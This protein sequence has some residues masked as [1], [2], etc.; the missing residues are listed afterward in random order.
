M[1]HIRCR[2]DFAAGVLFL[3]LGVFVLYELADVRLGTA[4]RMGPAYIPSLLA[5]GLI[6]TGGLIAIRAFL[7]SGAS[8][9][10]WAWKPLLLVCGGTAIF[11]LVVPQLGLFL[12]SIAITFV[13]SFGS[14]GMTIWKALAYG[15]LLA[16]AAGILFIGVLGLPMRLWPW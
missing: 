6:V 14:K 8:L 15:I 10:R 12:A 1:P 2:Q 13:V 9:D 5:W 16:A 7:T 11:G 3:V 4:M